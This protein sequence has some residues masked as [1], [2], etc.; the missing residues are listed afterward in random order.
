[1][2]TKLV[3]FREVKSRV[4]I[5]DVLSHYGFLESLKDKGGGKLVGPCPIH[6]GKNPN[7]FHVSGEKNAFNCFSKCGGGNVLDLVMKVEQC[8][9]REAALKLAD[10]FGIDAT[11]A[12]TEPA[13]GAAPR[14][15]K[16]VE[17]RVEATVRPS[18]DGKAAMATVK[19]EVEARVNP[20][21]DHELK[22][23]DY[24][25]P[26]L[27]ERGLAPE[28]VRTFGV[29]FCAR[30]LMKN[31]VAIEIRDAEGTLVAYAGRAVDPELAKEKGK[32][33]LPTGFHKSAVVYNL[34]RAK[35]H[36]GKGIVVVEG[37]FDAMT[38]N[39]A[40]YPNVVALMGSTLS[41][42]QEQ[43]LVAATDRLI[44]MFDGDEAGKKCV[45][46]FYGTLR[47]RVFLKEVQLAQGEQ[48]DQLSPERIRALLG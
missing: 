2:P 25:H 23:L 48:P 36:A 13:R 14:A 3:D 26:Y 40:G 33:L 44:L 8:N 29:G 32:Y 47:S 41:E 7:G 34:H 37:F 4:G 30:G 9:I 39:Q 5:R 15:S 12:A 38:V 18:L 19:C 11:R 27:T 31:R 17:E 6:G 1:M 21:L 22:T 28:T 10:W 16:V 35:E 43:L 46:Q 24:K 45:R 42:E 20:P